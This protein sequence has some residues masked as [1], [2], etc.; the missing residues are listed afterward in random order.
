MHR[1]Q[2]NRFLAAAAA[3]PSLAMGLDGAD[4]GRSHLKFTAAGDEFRFDTGSLRGALRAQGRSLGLQ[5][6]WES[7]SGKA[8][9]GPYGLFSPYRLLAADARFGTAAWDWA[10]RASLL[11]DGAVEVQWSADKDHPL[12]MTV[13]Y[14][15]AAEATLDVKTTVAPR[16]DL[17]RFELFLAS[18]FD[19]FAS[20]YGY[21]TGKAGFVEATQAAGDWQMFLRDEAAVPMIG[22]GRWKRPPN[23]VDWKIV[24]RQA[25]QFAVRRDAPTGLTAL[26]MSP[27]MDCFAISMPYSGEGH[28]SVYLSLFGCDLKAG[29]AASARARLMIGRGISNE[30]AVALYEEYSRAGRRCSTGS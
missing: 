16:S 17:S 26:L 30:K 9:A 5:P 4:A 21:V 23:P 27:P 14:Q 3:A 2:F 20:T 22:D 6:I 10:S 19:G 1:R 25:A 18:Y 29:K 13:V 7:G 12:D 11:P 28:R 15:F 8:V 24:S